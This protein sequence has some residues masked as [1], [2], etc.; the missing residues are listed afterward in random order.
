MPLFKT[1]RQKEIQ[2]IKDTLDKI[3]KKADKDKKDFNIDMVLNDARI[4]RA[5][6]YFCISEWS[7]PNILLFYAIREYKKAPT[8]SKGV[9]LLG[10]FCKESSEQ[11]VNIQ[12][13]DAKFAEEKLNQFHSK[14]HMTQSRRMAKLTPNISHRLREPP[15]PMNLFDTIEGTVKVNLLDTYSRFFLNPVPEIDK[16]AKIKISEERFKVLGIINTLSHFDLR[17][18]TLE[19]DLMN[20]TFW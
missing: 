5:F 10:T 9:A 17:L 19:G 12:D 4:R 13:K 2:Y 8:Y 6:L 7:Y 16:D 15:S 1:P 18:S 11:Q 14:I 3:K 20:L